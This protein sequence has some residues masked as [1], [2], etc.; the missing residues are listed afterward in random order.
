LSV[1]ADVVV[2][3]DGAYVYFTDLGGIPFFARN[4]GTGRLS[5]VEVEHG[6]AGGALVL[7]PGEEHIYTADFG[8]VGLYSRDAGTGLVTFVDAFGGYGL[9]GSNALAISPDGAHVYVT[10]SGFD[11]VVAFS[12]DAPTGLLTF[13]EAEQD[14][15]GG[16]DGLDG[17]H[18]VAI[19]ADGA[20]V[21][22]ASVEDDAVAVFS[23]NAGTGQLTFV[24]VLR[25]GVGGV[26][27]L[28]GASAITLSADGAYVYVAALDDAAVAIFGRNAGTG[29]LT[30]VGVERDGLERDAGI[31]GAERITIAPDGAHVYVSANETVV[32]FN[33]D[34]GTGQLALAQVLR[35]RVDGV[36]G[37]EDPVQIALSA[38]GSEVY[39]GGTTP[40]L[41]TAPAIAI[42][43]RDTGTGLLSYVM[44]ESRGRSGVAATSDGAY[45]YSGGTLGGLAVFVPGFAG[46]DPTPIAGCRTAGSGR[47]ALLRGRRVVTWTWS[48]GQATDVVHFGDP[49]TTTHY[50]F[51][52]YESDPGPALA[53]RALVPAGGKCRVPDFRGRFGRDCWKARTTGFVYTDRYRTPEGLQSIRLIAGDPAKIVVRGGKEHVGFPTLPLGLPVR[54]Q[55][56]ASNGNCWDTTY[57]AA[58]VNNADSFLARPN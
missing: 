55:L 12:R 13:V 22:V 32:V 50:A 16:V 41:G 9:G 51:C 42:F 11:E 17:A 8:S 4:A 49:T 31:G 1:P 15:V 6:G 26:D 54:V 58:S 35:H 25:D 37:I 7:S 29:Q 2:S 18:G 23:R 10:G 3:A 28:N 38:D 57:P 20:Y 27:G 21:Y 33:R 43:S 40:G 39:V 52:V 34:A 56:Q 47:I 53:L 45:V 48:R 19:S 5:S 46:C 30:F 14:G 44:R 36:E 24:E